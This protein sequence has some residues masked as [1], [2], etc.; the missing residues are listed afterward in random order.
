MSSLH[1][2]LLTSS[3]REPPHRWAIAYHASLVAVYA[4][5]A[6]GIV[7]LK[8]AMS[9]AVVDSVVFSFWRFVGSS[10]LLLL[11]VGISH[12]GMPRPPR[13]DLLSFVGL[14]C[15]LVLN[16]LC[17]NLGVQLAGA[18]ISTSLQP[19]TPVLSA[20][21]AV[22]AGQEKFS[23]TVLAAL[24]LA[25][26]GAILVALGRGDASSPGSHVSAGCLFITINTS[27]FAAYCVLMKPVVREHGAAVVT[28]AAQASGMLLMAA[29]LLLRP[30]FQTDCPGLSLPAAAYGALAYWIIAIS[31][32]SYLLIS[33]ANR[34]L[35]AST[36]VL[37]SVIQPVVGG[38]LS[39]IFL[40]ESLRPTDLGAVCIAIGLFIVAR[41][42]A[43]HV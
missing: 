40:G 6:T 42:P 2:H 21:M 1:D 10:L 26:S 9:E 4:I 7:Y 35:P 22:A 37:Y 20:A 39:V 14:G 25:V 43:A 24:L 16:Q 38:A 18:L 27:S 19:T 41:R 28:A 5:T 23:P 15:L 36:V 30:L 29:L 31:F 8:L 3:K 13:R 11:A 34:V 32:V 33:W 17:A 12:K